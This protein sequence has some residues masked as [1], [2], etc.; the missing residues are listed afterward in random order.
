MTESIA[1]VLADN[2]EVLLAR[3]HDT[4]AAIKGAL[5]R[6]VVGQEPIS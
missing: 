4:I 6:I 3:F 2:T 1:P 5:G